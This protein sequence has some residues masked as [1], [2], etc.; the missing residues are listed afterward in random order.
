MLVT[1]SPHYEITNTMRNRQS[2]ATRRVQID[3]T[4]E[5]SNPT[6]SSTGV[7]SPE[8]SEPIHATGGSNQ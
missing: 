1:V 4:A 3:L 7:L 6:K 8:S 5:Q 2:T